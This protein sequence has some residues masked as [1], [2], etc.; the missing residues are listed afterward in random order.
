MN[1]AT[2]PAQLHF[3]N[4]DRAT[5]AAVCDVI[6]DAAIAAGADAIW[7]EPST[8]AAD[9]YDV[10][11]ERGGSVL[12]AA[13]YDGG[14]GAALV[15]RLALLAEIDLVARRV[16]SGRV[17]VR[18]PAARV[19]LLVT[20]RPGRAPRADVALRRP[21]RRAAADGVAPVALGP[22]VMVG[23]YRIV[24][25][26]GAG[27]M[28]DV[29]RA[30]HPTL[31]RSYAVKVLGAKVASFHDEAM[32]RFLREARAA[33]RIKHPHIVDMLDFG[34]LPDSRPYLVMEYL[35]GQSLSARI[36]ARSLEP[37]SAIAI[38]RQ[39]ASALSAAHAVGVVHADVTPSNVLVQGDH[40]KLV[41]F[42][43]AQLRDD[44]SRLATEG[45]ADYVIGT[46]SYIA[47]ER[48]LGLAAGE[49]SDQYALGAVLFEMLTGAPPF[50]AATL[51][52]L[53]MKHLSHPVPSLDGLARPVPPELSGV[54]SRCL[55]KRPAQRFP[56][57]AALG[58]ALADAEEAMVLAGWRR[59][60]ER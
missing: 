7:L 14:F 6:V 47:P 27:G 52:E 20:L 12:A 10:S 4:D 28:G 44:T 34:Y 48:I 19:E 13:S 54:V 16:T 35:D 36:A 45:P 46:P 53:C 31:E 29:F 21:R 56:S 42:G 1:A 40:A 17:D 59:W 2:V 43:L 49:A 25:H 8:P 15:A 5:P 58:V 18:G 55:A 22:G 9:R 39:L 3:S 23:H 50:R 26:I 33:A 60:L 38:A 30:V 41:D 51:R 32:G 57:M 37:S 11:I 24:E